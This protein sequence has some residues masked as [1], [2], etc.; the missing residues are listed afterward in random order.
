MNI[1][2]NSAAAL[3]ETPNARDGSEYPPFRTLP[4]VSSNPKSKENDSIKN[5]TKNISE[6]IEWLNKYNKW[7]DAVDNRG[8]A[9]PLPT[10]IEDL[11]T[12]YIQGICD[13]QEYTYPSIND[14][15]DPLFLLELQ[16]AELQ[17]VLLKMGG[18]GI[19]R[20]R[21]NSQLISSYMTP[22]QKE[23]SLYLVTIG[24]PTDVSVEDTNSEQRKEYILRAIKSPSPGICL[25][26][27]EEA[28][29]SSI[30]DKT[31]D[32]DKQPYSIKRLFGQ[33]FS[34]NIIRPQ[35]G[36]YQV[37][38]DDNNGPIAEWLKANGISI[39]IEEDKEVD[40]TKEDEGVGEYVVGWKIIDTK[41]QNDGDKG[42]TVQQ[43]S[44][45]G[46]LGGL[47]VAI[48]KG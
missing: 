41:K 31:E 18:K 9:I 27:L 23:K 11:I 16:I 29:Q 14:K 8:E 33:T 22:A 4:I 26:A 21:Q 2:T 7:D 46:P 28:M 37:L 13:I 25:L 10:Y 17:K 24:E 40:K 3:H 45:Q 35:Y 36:L 47:A 43:E 15:V 20:A 30:F 12:F 19:E 42:E 1:E 44:P 34:I 48:T 39:T 32:K 6:F 5:A 38:I